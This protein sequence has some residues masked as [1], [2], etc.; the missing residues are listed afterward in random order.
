M[1]RRKYGTDA[2]YTYIIKALIIILLSTCFLIIL[3]CLI[4]HENTK[5]QSKD[6]Y[7]ITKFSI[8]SGTIVF[9][10]KISKQPKIKVYISS[11]K[12]I[13][14]IYIEDYV[15]GVVCGEMPAE[16]DIEA[17]KAQSVAARTYAFSHM[18]EFGGEKCNQGKGADVCDT[19]HC[20]VYMSKEARMK[21]WPKS[22]AQ[23]YWDKISEAVNQTAG[24]VIMYSGEMIKAPYYFSTSSG[25][26][27]DSIDVFA[28][29]MPYLKSVESPGEEASPKFTSTVKLTAGELSKKINAAF[30][31]A[32]M[33]SKNIKS[34]LVIKS[35]TQSGSV[36]EIKTGS[37][38]ISGSQ[39]RAVLGLNSSNFDIIYNA[40]NIEI[41]C[42]GNGHD[43]GMSQWGAYAMAKKGG[44][45]K[46]ILLHYYNGTTVENINADVWKTTD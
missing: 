16:F 19:V 30:P 34:C 17:L 46:E 28:F 15:R 8:N 40:K 2:I 36:K 35:R 41:I 42:R 6:N 11:Q 5:Q 32:N 3:P 9:N 38:T 39:F 24:Q 25:K 10:T 45:Y 31:Y 21:L 18:A 43:V 33:S 29:S 23:K 7:D 1:K 27:E 22:S 13:K 14:E 26:T 20:Q 37:T 44:S 12:K 4:L